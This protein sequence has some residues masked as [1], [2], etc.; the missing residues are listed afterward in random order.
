M[1]PVGSSQVQEYSFTEQGS[2]VTSGAALSNPMIIITDSE[3]CLG[4][5]RP[6]PTPLFFTRR[7]HLP[8]PATLSRRQ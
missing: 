6:L 2:E 4:V 1:V 5:N 8:R 7:N 3:S